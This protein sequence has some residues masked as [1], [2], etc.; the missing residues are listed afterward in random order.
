MEVAFKERGGTSL[1]WTAGAGGLQE[2]VRELHPSAVPGEGGWVGF[3]EDVG[4]HLGQ[5]QRREVTVTGPGLSFLP[6][7]AEGQ[8]T[9]V[10]DNEA[11]VSF[12]SA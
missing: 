3:W 8:A 6:L 1:T 12:S 4:P 7:D 5:S 9:W 2:W 10:R 11:Q